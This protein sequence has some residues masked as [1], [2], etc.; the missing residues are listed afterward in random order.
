MINS[1][2]AVDPLLQIA[3]QQFVCQSKWFKKY[4][5]LIELAQFHGILQQF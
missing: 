1:P 3:S 4:Y 5:M 2:Q